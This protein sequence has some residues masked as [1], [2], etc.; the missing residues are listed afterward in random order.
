MGCQFYGGFYLLFDAYVGTNK[1][2]ILPVRRRQSLA[3]LDLLENP[4]APNTK[5]LAAARA[6]PNPS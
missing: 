6:F 2:G 4:P 5:L 1:Y 3:A